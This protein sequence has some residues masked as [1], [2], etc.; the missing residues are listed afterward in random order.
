MIGHRVGQTSDGCV[1]SLTA[2][3]TKET[4]QS[5][6]S[7]AIS[8][9]QAFLDSSEAGLSGTVEEPGVSNVFDVDFY[10]RSGGHPSGVPPACTVHRVRPGPPQRRPL[11]PRKERQRLIQVGRLHSP[12]A[13]RIPEA[14]SLVFNVRLKPM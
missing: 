3:V 11:T 13:A 6:A 8:G 5:L 7:G 9:K 10:Q 12:L 2:R 1:Y 14:Q 4:F